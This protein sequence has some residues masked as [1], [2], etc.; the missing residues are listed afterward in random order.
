MKDDAR[1]EIERAHSMI[2]VLETALGSLEHLYFA[3]PD[4]KSSFL[5]PSYSDACI[6]VLGALAIS[7]DHSSA[8]EGPLAIKKIVEHERSINSDYIWMS[9]VK[10]TRVP[11]ERVSHNSIKRLLGKRCLVIE[12]WGE[13]FYCRVPHYIREGSSIGTSAIIGIP[14]PGMKW[15][16]PIIKGMQDVCRKIGQAK[17][18]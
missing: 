5:Q 15:N 13:K 8:N 12:K 18:A 10:D 1:K 4:A 16:L 6:H 14:P 7:F 2:N 3:F 17:T 9:Q 11:M